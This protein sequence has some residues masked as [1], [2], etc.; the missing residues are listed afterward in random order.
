M[1]EIIMLLSLFV[2]IYLYIYLGKPED[3][4]ITPGIFNMNDWIPT[5]ELAQPDYR[6]IQ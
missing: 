2:I 1:I 5:M 4:I 6:I 3:I